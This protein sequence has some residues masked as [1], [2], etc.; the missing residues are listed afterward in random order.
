MQAPRQHTQTGKRQDRADSFGLE[1]TRRDAAGDPKCPDH[2]R[3]CRRADSACSA[4]AFF[5]HV[6]A[7]N[8]S[9]VGR[10]SLAQWAMLPR[11]TRPRAI[12]LVA[13]AAMP[14]CS[15]CA[16]QAL[17][18][19]REAARRWVAAVEAGD[20]SAA[21]ALLRETARRAHGPQG[22]ARLLSSE[23][24][25]LL[26]LGRAA[27][28]DGAVLE[29]SADVDFGND[30]RARVVLEGGRFRVAAAGALPVGAATPRDALRELR[31]VL[32]R[33]SVA[34]LLRV[35]TRES[36]ESLDT[37]LSK[38]VEALAE[39]ASVELDVEGRRAT[40]Q[41]PGGHKVTLERE[42]GIWHV[43]DFD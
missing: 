17:P 12:R 18:D 31:D 20:E 37:G 26:A 10:H 16:S 29:T 35:L 25:E 8:G 14:W 7:G 11:L 39:P 28:A 41:L 24:P 21:Y 22:V 30:R 5:S 19:P 6:L 32:A 42:D 9:Q 3:L 23:R 2:Q 13:V 1:Q 36:A 4:L 40:A 33:R 27:A 34:G 43:K 15:A 38:L